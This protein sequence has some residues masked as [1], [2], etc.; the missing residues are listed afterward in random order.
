[1]PNTYFQFKQFRVD[2]THAGMKV[3]TDACLFGAWVANSLQKMEEEPKSVLD[4]G[5]GT[6]LLSLMIAQKTEKSQIHAVEIVKEVAYE[7]SINFENAKWT[8]RLSL[9][10]MAIEDYSARQPFDCIVTNPPFFESSLRG[11]DKV[12]NTAIHSYNL[13]QSELANRIEK[14]LHPNGNVFVLYP[15]REMIQFSKEMKNNGFRLIRKV[16]VYNQVDS[17]VFRVTAQFVK[18]NSPLNSEVTQLVIKRKDGLY[19]DD[20]W[21]LLCDYYLEY[22]N[23]SMHQNKE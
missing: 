22:N 2:Q 9:H 6:G 13:T 14:L 19:T 12:K 5:A 15:E 23:P 20:F 18:T 10:P 16:M 8:K 11:T 7:A 4:I 3:T 1:M 21:E 17:P